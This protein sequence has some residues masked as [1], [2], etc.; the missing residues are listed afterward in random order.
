MNTYRHS[1]TAICPSDGDVVQYSLQIDSARV[2]MAEDIVSECA[3]DGPIYHE[4]LADQ[5]HAALGGK[6]TMDATHR[7]VQITTTRGTA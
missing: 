7:G 6:H 1:F 3:F 4:A 2:I 5:L